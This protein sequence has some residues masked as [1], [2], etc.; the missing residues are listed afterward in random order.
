MH[1][2][3]V[4]RISRPR[5]WI[6]ELGPYAIGALTS[7]QLGQDVVSLYTIVF[8]LFFLFPANL[9][10]YGVN[11]IFDY[12]TDKL[13]PKKTEY[14][15]LVLPHERISLWTWILTT[16]VPFLGFAWFL[17]TPALL[18][19]ITFFFFAGMYS[20]PPI[21]AKAIPFLDS[22]FSAG[23]YVAT[24]AF[25][26]YLF[27]GT[28]FP[29]IPLLAGM[30]WSIAMHAYSAAPDIEA[31]AGAHLH[32]IATVLGKDRTIILCAG[33][34]A[35][36]ASLTYTYLGLPMALLGIVYCF[37]MTISL[38]TKTLE[39]FHKLYTYFPTLNTIAGM[40]LFFSILFH[41]FTIL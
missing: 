2:L 27:G 3:R 38:Q 6:Y 4:L 39:A 24:G 25:G 11:D 31:D 26:Y 17:S 10:I 7:I 40:I 20:A 36:S 14:E 18:S 23:H 32:T 16:S 41:R 33:L 22:I 19:L 15:A 29:L 9:F 8:A 21:R 12:E 30:F 35:A 34:Y 13:N 28:G 5:F 1:I 37:L